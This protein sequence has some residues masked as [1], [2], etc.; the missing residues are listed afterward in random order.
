MI[1]VTNEFHAKIGIRN[2]VMPGARMVMTVV[3]KFTAPRIVPKPE[4]ARPSIHRF[5]PTPG[6][7]VVL[8]NG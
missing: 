6:E 4:S 3:M 5:P 2:I 1:A 7:N 8:A